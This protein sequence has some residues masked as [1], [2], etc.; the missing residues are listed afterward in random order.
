MW[1]SHQPKE[2]NFASPLAGEYAI[3]AENNIDLE[4]SM[5][6][7]GLG[8]KVILALGIVEA[9]YG[10]VFFSVFIGNLKS[11]IAVNIVGGENCGGEGRGER[12]PSQEVF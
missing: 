6:R 11:V 7:D 2:L 3:S 4:K 12:A 10:E 5:S 9:Q 1:G 8:R